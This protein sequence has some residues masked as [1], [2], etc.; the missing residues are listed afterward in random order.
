MYVGL[1]VSARML[2]TGQELRL[3]VEQANERAFE[4]I[5]SEFQALLRG[6]LPAHGLDLVRAGRTAAEGVQFCLTRGGAAAAPG[7]GL[8]PPGP[9]QT[10]LGRLSGGERTLVALALMLAVRLPGASVSC[11]FCACFAA[12]RLCPSTDTMAAHVVNVHHLKLPSVSGLSLKITAVQRELQAKKEDALLQPPQ[13]VYVPGLQPPGA[14]EVPC[15]KAPVNRMRLG[16]RRQAACA[17]AGQRVLL[18]DE[19]DAALDEPHQARVAALLRQL[20]GSTGAAARQVLAVTHNAAFQAA[21]RLIQVDLLQTTS[22]AGLQRA[23]AGLTPLGALLCSTSKMRGVTCWLFS[24]VAH[25]L[26]VQMHGTQ[27]ALLRAICA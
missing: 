5:R 3:Q 7:A 13:Q 11:V 20:A 8:E 14:R 27:Q 12:A 4:A 22:A 26:A 1:E 25:A 23:C 15:H 10:A 19:V 9:V 18:L 6:L 16:R 2:L 21:G 24:R 17:G